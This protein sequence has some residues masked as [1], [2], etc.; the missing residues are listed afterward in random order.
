[1][2]ELEKKLSQV[3]KSQTQVESVGGSFVNAAAVL[4]LFVNVSDEWNIVY[5]RRTNNVRTHQ[6]EVSF[7]GGAYEPEDA[8]MVSTA[9]RETYEE[10]GI[11]PECIRI[12]G[13]LDPVRTISNFTV[14]PYVGIL[15][16]EPTFLINFNEVERVFM[17]PLK[18]LTDPLNF[19]EQDHLVEQQ[20]IRRVVHYNDFEGEHL[21]GLTARITQQLLE[22]Q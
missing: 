1:M 18:W 17:I 5:T 19:Y 14:Y 21:W 11:K 8:S 10:I 22:I 15:E 16:C 7:P 3:L 13:G 2:D 4:I 12:L 6:G 20:F 9:L